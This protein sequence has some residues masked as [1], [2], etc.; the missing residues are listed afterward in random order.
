M[1]M[2]H[3][4]IKPKPCKTTTHHCRLTDKTLQIHS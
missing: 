3:T 4:S 2:G 1:E